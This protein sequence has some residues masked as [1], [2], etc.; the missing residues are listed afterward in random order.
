[1]WVDD[2]AVA[3]PLC[4]CCGF[5]GSLRGSSPLKNLPAGENPLHLWIH[6]FE[7]NHV[8]DAFLGEFGIWTAGLFL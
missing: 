4:F 7:K 1:M 3:K 8:S 2:G 6:D 5:G